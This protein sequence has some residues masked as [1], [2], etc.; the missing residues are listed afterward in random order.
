MG[1]RNVLGPRFNALE[2]ELRQNAVENLNVPGSLLQQQIA[3]SI[4]QLKFSLCILFGCNWRYLITWRSPSHGERSRRPR[5]VYIYFSP[6]EVEVEEKRCGNEINSCMLFFSFFFSSSNS[7]LRRLLLP[8]AHSSGHTGLHQ[9]P[10]E[11]AAIAQWTTSFNFN[12]TVKNNR[13]LF[14]YDINKTR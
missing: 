11:D 12:N 5:L 14:D 2:S 10:T 4:P 13:N 1:N 9:K 7:L 6:F 8:E 3:Q